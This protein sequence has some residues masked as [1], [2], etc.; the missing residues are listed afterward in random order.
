MA[1]WGIF[2]TVAASALF[3]WHGIRGLRTGRASIPVKLFLDDEYQRGETMFGLAISL[4][5]LG[6]M[7]AMALSYVIWSSLL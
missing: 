5:F 6:S 7:L 1:W 2:L 3:A 4:N